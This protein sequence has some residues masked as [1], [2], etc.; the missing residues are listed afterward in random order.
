MHNAACRKELRCVSM[1]VSEHAAGI[2]APHSEVN[3]KAAL[4]SM[5]NLAPSKITPNVLEQVKADL[6]ALEKSIEKAA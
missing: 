2:V 4:E 1:H 6:A 5:L 3:K